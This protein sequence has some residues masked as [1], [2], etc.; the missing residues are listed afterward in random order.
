MLVRSTALVAI[1]FPKV[2]LSSLIGSLAYR[3]IIGLLL[4]FIKFFTI[5]F[6]SDLS[7]RG[8]WTMIFTTMEECAC[9]VCSCLPGTRPLVRRV[10]HE[11]GLREIVRSRYGKG[12]TLP[13]HI[14]N[15]LPAGNT[16]GFHPATTI[17]GNK[18]VPYSSQHNNTASIVRLQETF[19]IEPISRL[20]LLG[21]WDSEYAV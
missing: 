6:S 16:H 10:Y 19:H 3:G 9:F 12:K 5:N 17:T 7:Y 14:Y 13:N 4:R 2:A 1:K 11:S 18:V 15:H 21:G 8:I 20:T